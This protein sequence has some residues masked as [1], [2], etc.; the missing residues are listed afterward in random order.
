MA[1]KKKGNFHEL[2]LIKYSSGQISLKDNFLLFFSFLWE[3]RVEKYKQ[4]ERKKKKK[5]HKI[6]SLN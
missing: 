6:P 3:M 5:I 4:Q 2:K 1:K